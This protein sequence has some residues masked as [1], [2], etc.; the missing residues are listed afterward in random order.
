LLIII[1]P[2]EPSIGRDYIGRVFAIVVLGGMGSFPGML[3][4]DEQAAEAAGVP[5]LKLKLISTT[6]S[7]RSTARAAI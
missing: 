4:D 7:P 2:V 3:V 1:Q 5:T 6:S